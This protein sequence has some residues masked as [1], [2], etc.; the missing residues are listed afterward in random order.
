VICT[1]WPEYREIR[2]DGLARTMRRPLVLDPAGFLSASLGEST[3]LAYVRVG[4]PAF[5]DVAVTAP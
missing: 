5:E 1:A 3:D 4:T 2:A